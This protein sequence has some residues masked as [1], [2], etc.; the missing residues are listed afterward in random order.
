MHGGG[1]CIKE[2]ES[3]K[4]S[5]RVVQEGVKGAGKCI[6]PGGVKVAS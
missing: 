6:R 1:D 5:R 3:V 2:E 4:R